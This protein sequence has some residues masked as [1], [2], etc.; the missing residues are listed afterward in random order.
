MFK[1]QILENIEVSIPENIKIDMR[2]KFATNCAFML[3]FSINLKQMVEKNLDLKNIL[4]N[5]NEDALYFSGDILAKT[6]YYYWIKGGC[7]EEIFVENAQ[8]TAFYAG[9]KCIW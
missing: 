3:E 6:L 2:K 8:A 9:F 4:F 1:K 5:N 7:I